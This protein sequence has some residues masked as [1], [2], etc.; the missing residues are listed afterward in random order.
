MM[1]HS[2]LVRNLNANYTTYWDL[3]VTV[4]LANLKLSDDKIATILLRE[5]LH[6]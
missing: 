2:V 5:Q 1:L 3:V 6:F 4:R